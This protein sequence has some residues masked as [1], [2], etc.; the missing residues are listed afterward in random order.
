MEKLNVNL[1][2][3]TVVV[4]PLTLPPSNGNVPVDAPDGITLLCNDIIVGERANNMSLLIPQGIAVIGFYVITLPGGT[5]GIAP[6]SFANTPIEWQDDVSAN[7]FLVQNWNSGHFTVVDFNTVRLRSEHPFNVFVSYS[8]V[9]Y[10][11][12]PTI[13]NEPPMPT[14]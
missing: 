3:I 5:A 6:A 13:I 11:S 10:F 8:G 14:G 7:A 1:F 9:T 4:N 12:D 2:R